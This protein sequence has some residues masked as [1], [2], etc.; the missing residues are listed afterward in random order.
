MFHAGIAAKNSEPQ[1]KAPPRMET[2]E[3][4][5]GPAGRGNSVKSAEFHFSETHTTTCTHFAKLL[6]HFPTIKRVA[7]LKAPEKSQEDVSHGLVMTRES[8]L[9]RK[10]ANKKKAPGLRLPDRTSQEAQSDPTLEFSNATL[11][12][13]K[14]V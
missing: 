7:V 2:A 8:C 14:G 3:R 4:V 12:S 10:Q 1:G 6:H 9:L 11:G 5:P 13:A